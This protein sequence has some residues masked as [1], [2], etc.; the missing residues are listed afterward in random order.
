MNIKETINLECKGENY[1]DPSLLF[2]TKKLKKM[3]KI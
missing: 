2:L 3:F 1:K